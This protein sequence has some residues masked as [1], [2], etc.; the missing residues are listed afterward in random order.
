MGKEK[1]FPYT[2]SI[3]IEKFEPSS[4]MVKDLGTTIVQ[5]YECQNAIEQKLH[6]AED[7][8][9]HIATKYGTEEHAISTTHITSPV[10]PTIF[11][12]PRPSKKIEELLEDIKDVEGEEANP[13][14]QLH[15]RTKMAT[16][17]APATRR[18]IYSSQSTNSLR[19]S[20]TS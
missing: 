11:D 19:K 3:K 5:L 6:L 15:K 4:K 20:S 18:R 9:Q 16:K 1:A 10:T 17:N 8:S 14:P 12:A 2:P 13:L 7:K